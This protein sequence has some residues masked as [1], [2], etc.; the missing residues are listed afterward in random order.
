MKGWE[1]GKA[2][3]TLELKVRLEQ[4]FDLLFVVRR[5]DKLTE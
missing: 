1:L 3:V 2:R 5:K 4:V